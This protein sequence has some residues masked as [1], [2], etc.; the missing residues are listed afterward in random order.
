[1]TRCIS[2]KML[3][4]VDALSLIYSPHLYMS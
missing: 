2:K 1:M 4:E 3:L